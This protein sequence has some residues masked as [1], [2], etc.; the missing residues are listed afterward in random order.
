[1][2]AEA[3]AVATLSTVIT[4]LEMLAPPKRPYAAPPAHLKLALIRAERP[5]VAFS[6]FLYNTVG[7][8]WWWFERR[9]L[10]DR[11]LAAIVGDPRYETYVLHVGGTPGGYFELDRRESGLVEIAYFGLMPDCIGL[12]LGPFL[13]DQAIRIAWLG[14]PVPRRLWVNTCDMDHPRALP[15]Y[16]RAG[17]VPYDRRIKEFEDPRPAGLVPAG[18]QPNR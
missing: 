6:R 8:P 10:S 17:F 12:G 15:L 7:E 14:P 9:R 4:Y 13:L 18:P 11:E 2:S 16:Q 3:K 1:M 5:S